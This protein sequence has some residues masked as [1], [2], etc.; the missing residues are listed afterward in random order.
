M[1]IELPFIS[2][3]GGLSDRCYMT[4]NF[5]DMMHLTLQRR[6]VLYQLSLQIAPMIAQV[7]AAHILLNIQD[8]MQM[9]DPNHPTIDEMDEANDQHTV[10]FQ[11]ASL[12]ST[13]AQSAQDVLNFDMETAD[14]QPIDKTVSNLDAVPPLSEDRA[15]EAFP[16]DCVLSREVFFP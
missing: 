11:M 15:S 1:I 4:T 5:T 7:C 3:V 8:V 16:A 2:D 14:S 6:N 10:S 13:Q 12:L 9:S